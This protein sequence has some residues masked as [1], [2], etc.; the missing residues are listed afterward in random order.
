[1]VMGSALPYLTL[2]YLTLPYLTLP[3]LTLPRTLNL[4]H[5]ASADRISTHRGAA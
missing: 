2:P 4:D 5:T 1:M 3:Y